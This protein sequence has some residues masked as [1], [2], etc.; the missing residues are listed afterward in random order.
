[1]TKLFVNFPVVDLKKSMAFY[2]AIGFK[3]NPQ[4]TEETAAGMEWSESIYVMLLT[5]EKW[6]TFTNRPIPPATSSEVMVCISVTVARQPM[7]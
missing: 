7:K 6:R 4:F 1:M 5:H 2:D 3:N